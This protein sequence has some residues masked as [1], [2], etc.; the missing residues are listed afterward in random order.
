MVTTRRDFLK[1]ASAATVVSVG[2][3]PPGVLS[4]VAAAAPG[5]K[6]THGRVLVLVELAGGNDTINTVVPFGDDAYYKNR[7]GIGI[8]KG[9]V[10]KIDNYHGLH[11]SLSGFKELYDEGVLAIIQGV[12][13]PNPDR[14]HF[15]AMDIWHTARPEK[16]DLSSGWIGRALDNT[17]DEWAGKLPALGLGTERLPLALL[18][19]RVNVPTIHNLAQYRLHLGDDNSRK[20]RRELLGRLAQPRSGIPVSPVV[21]ATSELAF[22]RATATTAFVSADKLQE[23][24]ANYQPAIPYPNSGLGNKLKVVAQII[25]GEVGTQIFFV[26]LGGFD[27]HS[28]QEAAHA[29]LLGELSDGLRAFWGDLKEH[30]VADRVLVATF[31][32]FGRRVKENGSLG[33][34]HGAGTQMFAI[35]APGKG[36]IHGKHPSLTDLDDGD[37]KFHT[38]FRSVYSTLLHKWLGYDAAAV[39][40]K[41]YPTLNFV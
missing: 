1:Q 12:G 7:P 40:G 23:I 19:T 39:L 22:L 4:R 27:T 5:H 20:I 33:T 18:A 29:T 28:Q 17:A 24:A 30:K 25:A 35:T 31:S 32:E 2:C 34:D 21:S 9:A 16:E 41:P 14:S 6:P 11:P 26:S 15:R 3:L 36:G 37:L 13:Y 8:K 38:D 10:L